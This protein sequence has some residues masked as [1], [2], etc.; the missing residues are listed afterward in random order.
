MPTHEGES[1]QDSQLCRRLLLGVEEYPL[2]IQ[3]SCCIQQIGEDGRN[4]TDERASCQTY[5]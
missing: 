2:A 1:S 4:T 3:M 5:T